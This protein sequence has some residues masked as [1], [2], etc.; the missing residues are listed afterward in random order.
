MKIGTTFRGVVAVLSIIGLLAGGTPTGQAGAA[1]APDRPDLTGFAVSTNEVDLSWTP[2]TTPPISSYTIRRNNNVLATVGAAT[3]AYTDPTVSPRTTYVYTVE[4]IGAN[5]QSLP[6]SRPA[7]IK[8]PP[9]PDTPDTTPPSAPEDLFAVPVAGGVLLDWYYAIDDTDV[10]AYVVLRNG[11][12]IKIVDSATYSYVDSDVRPGQ[13]Y[14]YAIAAF[15]TVHHL[16]APSESVV[17]QVPPGSAAGTNAPP[18]N[19]P[20]APLAAAEVATAGYST[21]LQRYP[22]LTDV[23]NNYATVNWA[24]DNSGSTGSVTW[25]QVGSE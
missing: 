25:G 1:L 19:V 16:S 3:L 6:R 15:D 7:V 14:T 24:T 21:H 22:Y 20:N 8:T 11:R 9:L 13:T 4:A 10:T 5:G 17:V 18:A 12:R 23:V 2:V